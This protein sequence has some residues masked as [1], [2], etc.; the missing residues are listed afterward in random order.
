MIKKSAIIL[1]ILVLSLCLLA[2]CSDRGNNNTDN[3]GGYIEET[4]IFP[5]ETDCLEDARNKA[6]KVLGKDFE[7]ADLGGEEF[8]LVI[9]D[10]TEIYM[11]AEQEKSYLRAVDIQSELISEQL[12][13]NMIIKQPDYSVF[14]T[15]AKAAKNSGLF[16]A[17]LVCV[18]QKALGYM[19]ANDMV[20]NL[21]SLYGDVFVEDYF[22]QNSKVQSSGN[23]SYYG[24]AGKGCVTP[25]S[26]GCVYFNKKLTDSYGITDS[27]YASVEDGSWTLDKMYEF[28]MLCNKDSEDNEDITV[29]CASKSSNIVCE[30]F[31]SSG[32]KYMETGLSVVPSVAD[33]GERFASFVNKM[34]SVFSDRT[35]VYGEDMMLY[36]ENGSSLFYID[37]LENSDIIKGAYGLMPLPKFDESQDRYY[38][39]CNGNAK[40]FAVLNT[41]DHPQNVPMVLNAINDSAQIITEGWARDLLEYVLRDSKS[42]HIAKMIFEN[43][44]YDFAYMFGDDYQSVAQSTYIALDNAV[45]TK[46]GYT[47]SVN[48]Q[49]ARLKK[50]VA[51]IFP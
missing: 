4:G 1:M 23:N 26:Y 43:A 49:S 40:I 32:M 8:I 51:V 37:T 41:N 42:Y 28:R 12:R 3:S 29:A 44:S 39:F 22:D 25:A 35:F 15:E 48:K 17:D 21:N 31:G 13:C 5:P 24:I 46:A 20:A 45:V 34:K 7:D 11:Q 33:N 50:D 27:I 2:S 18:P 6:E 38:T 10:D 19:R 14:L 36:F 9:A 16:Y 47:D 30:L